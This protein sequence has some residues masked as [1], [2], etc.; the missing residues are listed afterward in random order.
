[1]RYIVLQSSDNKVLSVADIPF[2]YDYTIKDE[3]YLLI[4]YDEYAFNLMISDYFF[5]NNEFT[6]VTK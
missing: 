6:E 2:E 4:G 3:E 5:N 1:M